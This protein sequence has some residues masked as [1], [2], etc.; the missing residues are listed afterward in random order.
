MPLL[1]GMLYAI[2]FGM[3]AIKMFE[4][5]FDAWYAFDCRREAKKR[6]KELDALVDQAEQRN[7]QEAEKRAAN[8][9]SSSRQARPGSAHQK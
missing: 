5:V 9:H 4:W 8:R 2:A 1:E 3:L 6:K 7:V